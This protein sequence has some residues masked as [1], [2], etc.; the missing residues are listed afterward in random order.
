M[1]VIAGT[2]RGRTL[3]APSGRVRP[4]SDRVREAIFDMLGSL[5][6]LEGRSV[7]DLFAGTGALGIEALS[8]GASSVV[9]VD[10]DPRAL[11]SVRKNLLSVGLL[12]PTDSQRRAPRRRAAGPAY[13]ECGPEDPRVAGK[14][15]SPRSR[16]SVELV[17]AEVLEWL[18]RD[19]ASRTAGSLGQG[20]QAAQAA[21]AAQAGRAGP[22]S[23]VGGRGD[24]GRGGVRASRGRFDLALVDPPYVF[25][26][27]P[28]LLQLLEAE[29][30]V[31][32][33]NRPIE[34]PARFD[35][36]RA[37]R[38]GGTLVTVVRATGMPAR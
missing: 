36:T 31:L 6:D 3:R 4:T 8:R 25:D 17:G 12:D 35:V 23:G 18:R 22:G 2:S 5:L 34:V 38:Y 28:Q 14:D 26:H 7:V 33:S 37:K 32:E 21:Q 30:A 15:S 29:V 24:S 16:G 11:E 27:W 13:Y 9:F 1:R 19:A 10:S 20:R